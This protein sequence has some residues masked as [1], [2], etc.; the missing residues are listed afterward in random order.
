M[1]D[2]AYRAHVC[3]ASGAVTNGKRHKL[4]DRAHVGGRPEVLLQ[5]CATERRDE[6]KRRG[7]TSYHIFTPRPEFG[8][9]QKIKV[10]KRPAKEAHV[11]FTEAQIVACAKW[12]TPRLR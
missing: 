4:P 10:P 5:R 9:R 12:L 7:T 6:R 3:V 2:D 11:H 8:T 1:V